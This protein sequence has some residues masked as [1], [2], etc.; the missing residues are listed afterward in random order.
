M[1]RSDILREITEVLGGVPGWLDSSRMDS[2]STPGGRSRGSLG[3]RD[4][5]PAKKRWS[6]LERPRPFN[7]STELPSILSS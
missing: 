2:L 3:T 4:C 6:P 7:A 5:Q 1:A